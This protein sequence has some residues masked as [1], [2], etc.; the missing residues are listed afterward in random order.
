[1]ENPLACALRDAIIRITPSAISL[2]FMES[3]LRSD[4]PALP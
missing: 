1:L 4:V 3:I 2:R